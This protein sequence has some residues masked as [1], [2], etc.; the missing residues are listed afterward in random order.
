MGGML[1]SNHRALPCPGQVEASAIRVDV[2]GLT[3]G[4]EPGV[5]KRGKAGRVEL[6]REESTPCDLRMIGLG[7]SGHHEGKCLDEANEGVCVS[8]GNSALGP[9]DMPAFASQRLEHVCNE[10]IEDAVKA[11]RLKRPG[12]TPVN[13]LTHLRLGE[14][15]HEVK[16]DEVTL[17]GAAALRHAR[18]TRGRRTLAW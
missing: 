11:S 7:K 6:L 12:T 4:K 14:V 10:R 16:F 2:E 17:L 3:A 15:W 8:L 18:S 13:E 5:R 1:A 9:F